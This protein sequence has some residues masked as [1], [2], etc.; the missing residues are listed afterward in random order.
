MSVAFR[1]IDH[2]FGVT[3]VLRGID[4]VVA[5]GEI[6]C[7]LGP[8]GSGKTTLLRL[9]AGLETLQR[10]TIEINGHCV[11]QPGEQ[12]EPQ[13][14]G[15]GL[16]FQDHVLYPHLT[17]AEN[18]AFG[19]A[20]LPA[21]EQR[22][23]SAAMLKR[24]GLA[25]LGDRYPHMLSGGQQQ[26]VALARALAP[27]PSVML[28]DEPF[29]SI[30][31]SLRRALQQQARQELKAAGTTGIVVTHDAQEALALADR[32]A[33][34]EDGAVV[35]QGTPEVLWERPAA[36]SVA[37]ALLDVDPFPVQ[38]DGAQVHSAWGTLPAAAFVDQRQD[39]GAT[40]AGLAVLVPGRAR[41]VQPAQTQAS[42]TL[43]DQRFASRGTQVLLRS[44][45]DERALLSIT[46]EAVD[47][48]R[49]EGP[50]ALSLASRAG[51]LFDGE[52]QPAAS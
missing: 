17:A 9:A 3:S 5:R 47:D 34:L 29:A 13:A 12:L 6:L 21:K 4:L 50:A 10:G 32:I 31:G 46:V 43:A 44:V 39:G 25:G 38:L 16:V 15:V 18:V 23:R 48:V 19:L 37:T 49:L 45:Q 27:Q 30:D 52:G 33:Y 7:L 40:G 26:R 2:S 14:R 41:L 11:A 36:L 35:Q 20:S 8:S 51:F 28:L 1:D 42:A 22:E 24:V